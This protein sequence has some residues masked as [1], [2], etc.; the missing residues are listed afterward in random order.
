MAASKKQRIGIIII[1]VVMTVGTVGSFFV[2]ILANNNSMADQRREQEEYDK[3]LAEYQKQM[4]KIEEEQ[5]KEAEKLSAQYYDEFK[6]YESLPEPFDAGKVKSLET[7]D[8]KEGDGQEI[9]EDTRY[10]AYYIGWNSEGKVF[11]GSIEGD[12]LKLP[13]EGGVG[14]IEGWVRGVEGMKIGGVRVISIPGNLAEGLAPSAD[15]K[16]GAPLKFVVMAIPPANN[17]AEKEE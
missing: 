8:L 13:I 1:A 9:N 10:R 7:E 15:I 16:Q 12:R 4:V 14:L 17:D 2:M 11:D 5:K 3:Q 6:Q